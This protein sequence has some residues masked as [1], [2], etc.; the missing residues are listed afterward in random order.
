MAPPDEDIRFVVS[1]QRFRGV[2]P[3][4]WGTTPEGEETIYVV[5][6]ADDGHE[7]IIEDTLARCMERAA[8]ALR[9]LP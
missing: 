3:K 7:L 6:I 2:A 9:R 1:H 4:N 5:R 8:E